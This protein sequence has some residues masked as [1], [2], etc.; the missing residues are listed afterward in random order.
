MDK[1][2]WF[3][4]YKTEHLE[5]YGNVSCK[6]LC[7]RRPCVAEP[8][9]KYIGAERNRGC[10]SA[11]SDGAYTT[12][13]LLMVSR[14][15]EGGRAY[16]TFTR[17]V[18]FTIILECTPE[19]GHFHSVC[20]LWTEQISCNG[21]VHCTGVKFLKTIVALFLMYTGQGEQNLHQ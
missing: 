9:S 8:Q 17:L 12:T 5:E 11:L 21:C 3:I 6:I 13:W 10:V 1:G 4:C 7:F 14:V 16:P 20:I 15:K 18:Y 2:T 19:S